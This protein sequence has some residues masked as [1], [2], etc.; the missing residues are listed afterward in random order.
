MTGRAAK[1]EFTAKFDRSTM[2]QGRVVLA[3]GD[4]RS[5]VTVS[6]IIDTLD[7]DDEVVVTITYVRR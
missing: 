6:R 4:A 1:M 7:P 2:S 5:A 3:I